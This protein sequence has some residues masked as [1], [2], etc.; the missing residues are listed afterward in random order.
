MASSGEQYRIARH[1]KI[2]RRK[3]IL[4]IVSIVSFLSSGV[5][6]IVPTLQQAIQ[7]PQSAPAS[8]ELSLHQQ[9]QGFELVLQ[10][11][12]ENQVALYGLVNVRLRLQDVQGAIAPLE[13]LVKLQPEHRHYK[14]L[15]E[16]LK[17]QGDKSDRS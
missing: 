14:T 16:Q 8:T 10:R 6:A 17:K 2:E 15:L 13:K 1:Q 12:P 9:A 5:F 4:T 3:R 7:N 11:E